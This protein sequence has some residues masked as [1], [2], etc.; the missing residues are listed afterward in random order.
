MA[1]GP[2]Y[3]LPQRRRREGRTDY[4]KRI[5]MLK[6]RKPRFTVRLSNKNIRAQVIDYG[7]KG[8]S[9]IASASTQELKKYG[10]NATGNTP[11]AYLVGLLCAKKAVKAGKTE[12]I[13]D[14][15][16]TAPTKGSKTFAVLK[17][18]IDGG[19]AIPNKAVLPKEERINGKHIADYA[20]LLKADEEKYKRQFG[21]YLKNGTDPEKL[22]ELF[23][24][25]K[26][27]IGAI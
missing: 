2:R 19:L 18:A 21:A 7:Q 20:K 14:A 27:K 15:G 23:K 26:E 10:W 1:E 3:R 12:A 22:P 25:A 6:S 24:L 11:S 5:K 8:D 4:R 9:T 17:G 16:V 13:L